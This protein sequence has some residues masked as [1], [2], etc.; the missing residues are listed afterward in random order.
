M[1]IPVLSDHGS[2][3][4]PP[5]YG[6]DVT[7]K[8]LSAEYTGDETGS[9]ETGWVGLR[10]KA[11][12]GKGES[13]VSGLNMVC[14]HVCMCVYA[15]VTRRYPKQLKFFHSRVCSPTCYIQ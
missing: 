4:V 10:R 1:F 8:H 9:V 2:T 11:Q 7:P 12:G 5:L 3:V 13:S 6:A 14:M 15:C